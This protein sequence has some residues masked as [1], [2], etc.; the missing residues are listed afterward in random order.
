M[1]AATV[2][3]KPSASA[4]IAA[5]TKV[6]RERW[7]AWVHELADGRELAVDPLEVVQTAAL[8]DRRDPG[9][10]LEAD[11]Q[12]VR[13][14]RDLEAKAEAVRA[15]IAAT[16]AKHGGLDA[17][18]ARVAELRAELRQIEK[19]AGPNPA[20]MT[21][22]QFAGEAM[23]LKRDNPHL[24]PRADEPKRTATSRRASR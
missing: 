5:A 22:G 4:S 10:A 11:A 17:I 20:Y 3:K 24:Y 14:V 1:P 16:L 2:T 7:L 15:R 21:A 6:A 19:L 18:R 12:V 13:R 23:R 8:L 9:P